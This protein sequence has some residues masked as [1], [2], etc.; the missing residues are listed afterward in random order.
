M[1]ARVGSRF[2][3]TAI[4][5]LMG[6]MLDACGGPPK[7]VYPGILT[8]SGPKVVP[9][10]TRYS[11]VSNCPVAADWTV[12]GPGSPTSAKG[13]DLAISWGAGPANAA[14]DVVCGSLKPAHVA[15]EV[16]QVDISAITVT[17]G[18]KAT[19]RNAPPLKV[20]DTSGPPAAIK[21]AADVSV[22]GPNASPHWGGRITTGFVQRLVAADTSQW[23]GEYADNA[24]P[25]HQNE[26]KADTTTDPPPKSDCIG[27]AQTCEAWYAFPAPFTYAPPA[28]AKGKIWINDSPGPGWPL[29]DKNGLT[30]REAHALWKFE[31]YV[32]VQSLDAPGLFFR[33]AVAKWSL[34]VTFTSPTTATGVVAPN[35]APMTADVDPDPD[36]C[37]VG[38]TAVNYW[39]NNIV[40]FR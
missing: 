14:I 36:S 30:L 37:P 35:P 5:L 2:A 38:G 33:R 24:N 10:T 23:K 27:S 18:G 34:E 29:K 26:L 17:I 25:P 40:A 22:K 16:V 4:C 28:S 9:D 3:G 6:V 11:Y 13:R 1:G 7:V 8:I 21:F 19:P 20:V 32:C 31:T 39:L 12:T 15:V